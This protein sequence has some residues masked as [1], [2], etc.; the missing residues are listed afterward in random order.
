MSFAVP[1]SASTLPPL[2]ERT[3]SLAGQTWLTAVA[4]RPAP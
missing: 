3:A 2:A 4:R 1:R